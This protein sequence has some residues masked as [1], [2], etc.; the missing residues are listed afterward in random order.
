VRGKK[1]HWGKKDGNC[2]LTKEKRG[3]NV[4]VIQRRSLS[5]RKELLGEVLMA[6][7]Q[8]VPGEGSHL[9]LSACEEGLNIIL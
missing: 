1:K 6:S 3:E 5:N 8:R 7:R 2:V 4:S 9:N